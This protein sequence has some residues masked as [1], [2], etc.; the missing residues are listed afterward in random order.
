MK[1]D[2]NRAR[3][4]GFYLL[5]GVIILAVIFYLT[6]PAEQKEYT[7]SE[8]EELF[9][10]EQVK[11]FCLEGD[12]LTLNLYSP[13]S[14]GNTTI[15]KTLSNPTWFREDLGDLI[16]QQTASGVLTEY[17]YVK[18]WT[19]PWWMSILPYLITIVL[20]VGVWFLLMNKAGGGGAHD[21]V[22]SGKGHDARPGAQ[23]ALCGQ[24]CSAPVE[25][26]A[27]HGQ[28]TAKGALMAVPR[29]AGDIL[30]DKF[31]GNFNSHHSTSGRTI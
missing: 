18:G 14:D 21:R 26:A 17:D 22:H 29:A 8:I 11:S 2:K 25:C 23:C 6:T 20:F 10:Q 1:P 7:Y 12:E 31:F 24:Q 16:E 27:R 9:R 28:H 5:I 3:G 15:K 13:D 19:A 4:I 30:P